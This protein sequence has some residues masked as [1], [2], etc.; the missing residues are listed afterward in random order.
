MRDDFVNKFNISVAP[1]A[2]K[3]WYLNGGVFETFELN[4]HR[5]NHRLL[6]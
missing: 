6:D 2:Q 3:A 5:Y 4:H 1:K